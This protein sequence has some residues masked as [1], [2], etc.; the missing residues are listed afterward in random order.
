MHVAAWQFVGPLLLLYL[1][2][3]MPFILFLRLFTVGLTALQFISPSVTLLNH[4][5]HIF[6]VHFCLQ[7]FLAHTLHSFNHWFCQWRGTHVF[8]DPFPN[9]RQAI[10][11]A[12]ET[13]D[14]FFNFKRDCTERYNAPHSTLVTTFLLY[15]ED[16]FH[17][18]IFI[19]S[20]KYESFHIFPFMSFPPSGVLQTQ[21]DLLSRWLD[22]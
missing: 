22:L 13:A 9:T 2:P 1:N 5:P 3:L 16:N 10:K 20:A 8:G 14:S 12:R 19:C 17:F 21:N 18:H 7:Q 6:S 4:N 11:V 15:C